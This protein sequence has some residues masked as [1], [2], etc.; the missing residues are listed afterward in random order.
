VYPTIGGSGPTSLM[1]SDLGIPTIMTGNVANPESRIHS[2]NE[3]ILLDD[4]FEAIGYFARFFERF[5]S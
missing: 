1:V 4:Y 3:S 2:P 5:A